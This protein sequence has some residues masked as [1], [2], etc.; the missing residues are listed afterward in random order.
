MRCLWDIKI[1]TEC[2]VKRMNRGGRKF[3]KK[4]KAREV[5]GNFIRK[6]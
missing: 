1:E 2:E 3:K 5:G 4:K 6:M